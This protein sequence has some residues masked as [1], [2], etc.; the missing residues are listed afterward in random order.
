M[1]GGVGDPSFFYVVDIEFRLGPLQ[2]SRASEK[3]FMPFEVGNVMCA[4]KFRGA[5]KYW[6]LF[7]GLLGE[8][9][10]FCVKRIGPFS[11]VSAESVAITAVSINVIKLS[12]R[13]RRSFASILYNGIVFV[14]VHYPFMNPTALLLLRFRIE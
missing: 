14:F 11:R 12:K 5:L 2:F 10:L 13:R 9:R 1:D 4:E 6:S 7:T 8:H 3:P